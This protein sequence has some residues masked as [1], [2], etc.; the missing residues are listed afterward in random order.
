VVDFKLK[1]VWGPTPSYPLVESFKSS[2]K[3]KIFIAGPCAVESIDSIW[4]IAEKVSKLGATHL[5]GG[6]F[7]A[8]TYPGAQFGLVSD[9]LLRSYREASSY[10]GLKNIIE[11]L[12]YSDDSINKIYNCCDCFQVGARSQQNYTLLRKLAA[13]G[14]PI[15]LKRNPGSTLDEFLGSAEHVLKSQKK[16]DLCLIERGSSTF[17]NHTRWTLSIS[18]IAAIKTITKLPII[19]DASHGTGRFDLVE[20]MTLAGMAAG[21]DGCLVEVHNDPRNSLSDADQ[22]IGF[23]EYRKLMKK[24][25]NMLEV[26]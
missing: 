11:V 8:G 18:M 25:N 26:L 1:R 5:R 24:I 21:A 4:M 2:L 12:D 22:A 13:T 15:F 14:K 7:R 9:D 17:E 10:Y 6:V 19:V 23:T 20:P 16:K 3:H